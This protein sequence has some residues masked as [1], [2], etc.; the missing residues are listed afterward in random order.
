[1]IIFIFPILCFFLEL[2][3]KIKTLSIKKKY[4][5]IYNNE[6]IKSKR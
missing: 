1:M 2:E 6:R 4:T 3:N 5:S